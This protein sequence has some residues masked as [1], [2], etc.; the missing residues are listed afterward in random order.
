[1]VRAAILN[2]DDPGKMSR[3]NRQP[4]TLVLRCT[5]CRRPEAPFV[6][7]ENGKDYCVSCA[8]KIRDVMRFRSAG[9]RANDI[10]ID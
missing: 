7:M 5:T 2:V 3:T 1:M 6:Y 8:R 9:R 4:R 10:H